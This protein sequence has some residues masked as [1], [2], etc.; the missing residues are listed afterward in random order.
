MNYE[1]SELDFLEYLKE[2]CKKEL[3]INGLRIE[4]DKSISNYLKRRK[5]LY[6]LYLINIKINKLN[7][8]EK[9][10]ELKK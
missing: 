2:I 3:I 7:K 8:K 9:S 6:K 4:E 10:K 1:I 5:L